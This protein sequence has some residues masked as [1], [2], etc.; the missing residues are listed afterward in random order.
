MQMES[1]RSVIL[2]SRKSADIA[3]VFRKGGHIVILTMEFPFQII[4]LCPQN[5]ILSQDIIAHT[6]MRVKLIRCYR[7][8]RINVWDGWAIHLLIFLISFAFICFCF[9]WMD[10][11]TVLATAWLFILT[12]RAELASS[13]G[14]RLLVHHD[15]YYNWKVLKVLQRNDNKIFSNYSLI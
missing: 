13:E 3:I 15:S 11:T 6:H 9:H 4:V 2:W 10:W 7:H 5:R 1:P 12:M 8:S 14:I